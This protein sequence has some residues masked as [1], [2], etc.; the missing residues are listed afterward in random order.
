MDALKGI[1]RGRYNQG[2]NSLAVYGLTRPVRGH[3]AV[4]KIINRKGLDSN[5]LDKI[6]VEVANLRQVEQLLG[7][8]RK[9]KLDYIVMR[10]MGVPIEELELDGETLED[11]KADAFQR[12]Q[13]LYHLIHE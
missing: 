4:V 7:W 13:D 12:Y 2:S 1:D 3:D 11:E 5:A 6:K 9:K 10:K 8:A